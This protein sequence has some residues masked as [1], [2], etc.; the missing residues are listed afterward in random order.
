M[1]RWMM[2]IVAGAFV[3]AFSALPPILGFVLG[4]SAVWVVILFHEGDRMAAEDFASD[5]QDE[6]EGY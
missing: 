4:V 3:A 6:W 2:S 1:T 5:G